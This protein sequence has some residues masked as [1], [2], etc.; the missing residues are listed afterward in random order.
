M[1][2]K[3]ILIG[4]D[5]SKFADNA[6]HY[7]FDIAHKFNARVGLVHI[8]EPAVMPYTNTND[9]L[10]GA[11]D[12]GMAEVQLIDIQ[13]NNS[14]II[15]DNVVKK[16]GGDLEITH[17]NEF[18]DT[19]D[20]IIRCSQDFDADMIVIGTHSRTGF[21]RFIMGSVAEHVVRHATVP[22]LVVPLKEEE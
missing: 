7:A 4:V 22:V 16:Y 9:P 15:I 17:F 10:S 21:D 14:K 19:A 8:V 5:N 3:K 2:I 20:G 11:P 18:G 12:M 1:L 13:K 6:A